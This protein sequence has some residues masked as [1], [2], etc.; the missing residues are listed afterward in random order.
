MLVAQGEQ[1][2]KHTVFS[3]AVDFHPDCR[4]VEPWKSTV[5]ILAL[6]DGAD[7]RPPA[8]LC[9]D[10]AELV[11]APPAVSIVACPG[12]RDAFDV[13]ELAAKRRY[14]FGTMGYNPEAAVIARTEVD[15]FLRSAR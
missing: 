3:R 5:P 14:G 1:T 6:L 13:P 15:R 4:A 2:E 7:D 12:V 8:R 11:A 10:L 9:Q